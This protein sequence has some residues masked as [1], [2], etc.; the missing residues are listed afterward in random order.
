[1]PSLSAAG[2]VLLLALVCL[3]T[4]DPKGSS[5]LDTEG[6]SQSVGVG[7]GYILGEQATRALAAVSGR[8]KV[9]EEEGADD[10]ISVT[11][12]SSGSSA[13]LGLRPQDLMPL[14]PQDLRKEPG[15]GKAKGKA[16]GGGKVAKKL[17]V[18]A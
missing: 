13:T 8:V 1:V 6:G 14:L 11:R 16:S 12:T 17:R 3:M 7:Q 15:R 4:A 2:R 10:D 9:K 18:G 5:H